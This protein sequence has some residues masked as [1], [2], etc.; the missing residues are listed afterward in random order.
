M[1]LLEM[2]ITMSE[3]NSTLDGMSSRLDI[4]KELSGLE[5]LP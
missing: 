3:I 4:T 5:T 2:N 1:V